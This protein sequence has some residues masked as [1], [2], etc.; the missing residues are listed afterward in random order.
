VHKQCSALQSEHCQGSRLTAACVNKLYIKKDEV[1][2]TEQSHFM[3]FLCGYLKLKKDL[4]NFD[5]AID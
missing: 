5:F 1:G 4:I 3:L 2:K